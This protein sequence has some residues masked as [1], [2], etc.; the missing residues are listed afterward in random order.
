MKIYLAG[1]LFSDA[2]RNFLDT[3]AARL[4]AAREAAGHPA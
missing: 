4:R 1:P 2:E 3:V